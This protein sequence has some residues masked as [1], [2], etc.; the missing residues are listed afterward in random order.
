MTASPVYPPIVHDSDFIAVDTDNE[1]GIQNYFGAFV[2]NLHAFLNQLPCLRDLQKTRRRWKPRT[3][4]TD[5]FG[6]FATDLEHWYTFNHGGRNEAQFNFGFHPT[7]V[8]IG[9]G[10]E[11]SKRK[12]GDPTV[13]G[14]AYACFVNVIRK[15]LDGFRRFVERNSFEV[16]WYGGQ[17]LSFQIIPTERVVDCLLNLLPEPSWVFVGRLLR[18]G[19][20]ALVL[21]DEGRLAEVIREVFCGFRPIWEQT[22]IMAHELSRS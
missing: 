12:G 20:D 1:T 22:Q 21:E 2:R 17:P 11:F 16:E 8:R 7:H 3:A 13:V 14:L 5:A 9:L 18:R 15:D 6:A 19:T 4:E 10:F